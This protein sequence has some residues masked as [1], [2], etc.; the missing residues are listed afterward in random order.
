MMD[1][2]DE[3]RDAKRSAYLTACDKIY[4]IPMIRWSFVFC[5]VCFL[6]VDGD[7]LFYSDIGKCE[8]HH[9]SNQVNAQICCDK[10][11][12]ISETGCT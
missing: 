4:R 8:V 3:Y 6:Y 12:I 9:L 1:L 10:F 2:E 7:V 5:W 11:I